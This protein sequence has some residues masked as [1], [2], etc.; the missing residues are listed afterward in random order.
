MIL[1]ADWVVPVAGEPIA[2]GEVVV[3]NGV[4]VDIR[5]RSGTRG[6]ADVLDFG[7]AVILPGLVNAHTHL[8]LTALRGA[9]EDLPFFEW[10]RKL[11]DLKKGLSE[12]EWRIS[13]LWGA[14][15]AAASGIT[16]VADTTDTGTSLY[17]M[18]QTGLRGR[19]YQEVFAVEPD[20]DPQ[21]TLRNLEN[22]LQWLHRS[23][24]GTAVEV[25]VAPHTLF[26]VRPHILQ[27]LRDYTREKGYPVCI[28]AAESQDEI[29][30]L[31]RGE[32][33]FAQMYAERG[34]PWQAQGKHPLDILH[35]QGWLNER[36]L[37]VHCVHTEP[38]HTEL[39]ASTQTAVAHCPQSNAKLYNG[40]APLNEWLAL[41]VAVGWGTDSAVSNNTLD[42]FT[43]MRVGVLLQRARH[44]VDKCI[45]SRKAVDLATLGGAQAL[46]MAEHI[47]TLEPGK[48]ADLCVVSLGKPRQFPAYD[49]YTALVFSTCASDVLMT[50]V[51]GKIVYRQ[52][53]YPLL[54]EPMTALRERLRH[55][56]RR[57]REV[58]NG[59]EPR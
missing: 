3:H 20:A 44:D 34:I 1:R 5:R 56:I 28:H 10:I 48:Q 17:A 53:E 19:V 8:E 40:I 31:E 27:A 30:L 23:A 14:L 4:I 51:G 32:G 13:A 9:V 36:T 26:T 42:L 35:Q 29:A 22:K 16:T 18:V 54:R 57:V 59:H 24:Q 52:G 45:T 50:M 7:E 49:P 37:L 25:G 55:T 21:R 43:E 33:K 6:G 15:E 12:P 38:R 11:V 39:L 2:E 58:L 46:G 47:G 41:G